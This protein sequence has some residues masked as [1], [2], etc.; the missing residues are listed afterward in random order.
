[1]I[2]NIT[3][4]WDLALLYL[5]S[6]VVLAF[7]VAH[8]YQ[9]LIIHFPVLTA[10]GIFF[11]GLFIESLSFRE[12]KASYVQRSGFFAALLFGLYSLVVF[13]LHLMQ[14]G[15]FYADFFYFMGIILSLC[16]LILRLMARW[17]LGEYFSYSIQISENH[18]LITRGIYRYIKHPAYLGTWLF[19]FGLPILL[20]V[21]P[22]F[23][24][25]II[26]VPFHFSRVK[27]EDEMLKNHFNR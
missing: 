12:K 9:D 11:V 17:T 7:S 19:L 24:L 1:M 2:G 27:R 3:F 13:M 14:F 6:L 23:I 8:Y 26:V 10:Y 4:R 15:R 5:V 20:G 21:W 16:G 18:K 22:P 25:L